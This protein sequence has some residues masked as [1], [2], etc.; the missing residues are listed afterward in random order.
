[1]EIGRSTFGT[2]WTLQSPNHTLKLCGID[3]SRGVRIKNAAQSSKQ[4][5]IRDFMSLAIRD[6]SEK[7]KENH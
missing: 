4:V 2:F 6:K 1:M 5:S 7:I 3:S